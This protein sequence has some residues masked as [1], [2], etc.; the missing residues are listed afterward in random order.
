M[1]WSSTPRP[2]RYSGP[3][4]TC[5]RARTAF[6]CACAAGGPWPSRYPGFHDRCT[7]RDTAPIITSLPDTEA[8]A[9]TPYEY[10]VRAQDAED[11][12]LV[13]RLSPAPSSMTI[14]EA[15]GLIQWV[16]TDSDLGLNPVTVTVLDGQGGMT[17]QSYEITVVADATNRDPV[18]GSTPRE[19]IGLGGNY[20]YRVAATDG[21]G[22]PLTT[23]LVTAPSGMTL[24]R[25]AIN[26]LGPGSRP[27]G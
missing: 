27:D 22:D 23:T 9:D 1:A 12:S 17:S 7:A 8:V 13:Y 10:Q 14:D 21:D 4:A 6:C 3:R 5:R 15:T 18:I 11:T 25:E 20:F 19:Q 2:G 24:E 26:P 16:P